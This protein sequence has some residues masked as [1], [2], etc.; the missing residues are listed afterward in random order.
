M[1]IYIKSVNFFTVTGM[2]RAESVTCVTLSHQYI[3]EVRHITPK[4][5][6]IDHHRNISIQKALVETVFDLC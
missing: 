3:M 4:F 1:P 2:G 5:A 6:N